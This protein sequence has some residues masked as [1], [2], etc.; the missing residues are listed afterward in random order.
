MGFKLRTSLSVA[1]GL[2][3][4]YMTMVMWSDAPVYVSVMFALSGVLVSYHFFKTKS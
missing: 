2:L 1:I 4:G 3:S